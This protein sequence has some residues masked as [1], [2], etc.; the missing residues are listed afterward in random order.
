MYGLKSWELRNKKNVCR[1]GSMV[2]LWRTPHADITVRQR[3]N[4]GRRKKP[5]RSELVLLKFWLKS[6]L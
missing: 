5:A 6:N 3:L 2:F 1:M 4:I